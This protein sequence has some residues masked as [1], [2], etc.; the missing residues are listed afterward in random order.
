MS[1]ILRTCVCVATFKNQSV[2]CGAQSPHFS[3][4]S[5]VFLIPFLIVSYHARDGN[6]G[7]I[8]S[9]PLL[10]IW[11]WPKLIL[12][13]ERAIQEVFRPLSESYCNFYE[14]MGRGELKISLCN[15]LELLCSIYVSP[16]LLLMRSQPPFVSLFLFCFM[17]VFLQC[18]QGCLFLW[19]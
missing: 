18:L 11:M 15:S 17:M 1:D 13:C 10:L 14:F 5:S 3:E 12:C 8:V 16:P 2:S 19:I 9:L 6:F 7:E 4:R